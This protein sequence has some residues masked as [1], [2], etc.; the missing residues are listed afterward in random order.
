MTAPTTSELARKHP[1]QIVHVQPERRPR[2]VFAAD[3]GGS[4]PFVLYL[5]LGMVVA[6]FALAL[7]AATL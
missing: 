2:S 4:G 1:A 7:L 6:F 5:L 3:N